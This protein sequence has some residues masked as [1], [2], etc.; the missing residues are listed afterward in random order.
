MFGEVENFRAG[1]LPDGVN[2]LSESQQL[3]EARDK[4]HRVSGLFKKRI[5]A[6]FRGQRSEILSARK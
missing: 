4:T 2:F 1:E 6:G 5:R 3:F